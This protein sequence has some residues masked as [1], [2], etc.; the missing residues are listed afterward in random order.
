MPAK[1]TMTVLIEG[2]ASN[3]KRHQMAKAERRGYWQGVVVTMV[4]WIT[5]NL[6]HGPWWLDFVGALGV[7]IIAG[8][9][10]VWVGTMTEREA[11]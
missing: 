3:T 8:L 10:M 7:G 6:I 2:D 4:V 5:T 9:I 11:K 1:R